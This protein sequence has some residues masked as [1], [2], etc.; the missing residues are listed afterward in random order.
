MVKALIFDIDGTLVDTVDL[1]ARAWADAFRHFGR[2]VAF[3]DVRQQ[4]GK[5]GDQLIPVFLPPEEVKRIGAELDHWRGRL[6]QQRYLP[7][8]RAFPKVRQLF[9]RA[10]AAGQKIALASSCKRDEL[11]N[12]MRLAQVED[13]IDAETS[14]DDAER[15]KPYPDIFVAALNKLAPIRPAEAVVIGDAPYDGQA[16]RRLGLRAV[17]LRCGGF[18]EE[19]LRRAGCVAIYNDPADLLKNYEISPAAPDSGG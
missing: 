18:A 7:M 17:G 12:Y 14:A 16:A 6:Y 4:I 2:H 15:S 13:L 3:H 1:H 11:E 19:D 9:E 8:A 10:K 5:G